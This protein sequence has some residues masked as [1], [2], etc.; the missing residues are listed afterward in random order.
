MRLYGPPP[1]AAQRLVDVPMAAWAVSIVV[2]VLAVAVGLS[3]LRRRSS[4]VAAMGL[5]TLGGTAL[6]TAP[7]LGMIPIA[8]F[9]SFPTIDKAGSLHFFRDGVH[10]RLFEASDPG[11]QLIGVHLGHLWIVQVLA[12]PL[13]APLPALFPDWAAFNAQSFL[14]LWLAGWCAAAWLVHRSGDVRVAL[15]LALPFALN[16]HQFRDINWYTVEK[17]AI[18]L[19][20]LWLLCLDTR[21]WAACFAVGALAMF[22]NVYMGILI[23]TMG[24]WTTAAELARGARRDPSRLLC[25]AMSALG[26]LPFAL[27]QGVL[28]RGAHA[29]GSPEDFLTQRAALDVLSLSPW[30][31]NRLEG[32]RAMNLAVLTLAG[33]WLYGELI[34]R[35]GGG[36]LVG[37][38]LCTL[39]ALG[40]SANP[41]YMA[42][43]DLVPGFWRVAKP[44]TFFWV[45][46]L[47]LVTAAA[48][49][50]ASMRLPNRAMLLVAALFLVG[51]LVGVRAHPV[52]PDFYSSPR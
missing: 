9:G 42:L 40:P 15:L 50:L 29:P 45:S 28:M 41:V 37:V 6:L 36:W 27:W 10:W 49:A 8:V 43:F 26:M 52:Y 51:W 17:T 46:W 23:A 25:V 24:A 7:M 18:F 4:S 1:D 31:W 16:L 48:E 35:R 19:L 22:L 21:R 39:L 2:G 12:A 47:L 30:E 38:V 11:V 13:P 32:W 3:V 20:P 5:L 33:L 44:E 34:W 14:N